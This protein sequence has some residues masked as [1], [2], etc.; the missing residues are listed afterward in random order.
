MV[1]SYCINFPL[2][3]CLPCCTCL[4]VLPH[5]FL[6]YFHLNLFCLTNQTIFSYHLKPFVLMISH[7]ANFCII[8]KLLSCTLH[9]SKSSIYIAN[10]KLMEYWAMWNCSDNSLLVIKPLFCSFQRQ[11]WIRFDTLSEYT[12][13]F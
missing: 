13:L 6:N 10:D 4:N 5:T 12:F 9:R 7:R 8:W 2:L 3:Y 11:F 1:Y